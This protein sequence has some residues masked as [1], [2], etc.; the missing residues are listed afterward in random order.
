[1]VD[2]LWFN[3]IEPMADGRDDGDD[4]WIFFFIEN[5]P[6]KRERL[7]GTDLASSTR[8]QNIVSDV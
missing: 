8:E 2:D 4:G 3:K 5:A 1:M 6:R 7:Y